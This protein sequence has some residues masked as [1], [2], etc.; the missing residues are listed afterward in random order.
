MEELY[1][2]YETDRLTLQ[3]LE[4]LRSA[5]LTEVN[6]ELEDFMRNEWMGGNLN[7]LEVPDDTQNRVRSN[8]MRQISSKHFLIPLYVKVIGW[9]AGILLPLF[10]ISTFYLY[11]ENKQ[12]VSEEMIVS[13]GIGERATI[14]LPDNTKVTLN[15]ESRLVY[16]PKIY[17]KEERRI[18]FS[19]EG[20]FNVAK[21]AERPFLIDAKGLN[22]KVLGTKFNLLVRNDEP[23][24]ELSLESGSVRFSSIVSGKYAILKPSQKVIMDQ[25]TGKLIVVG[26]EIR[27]I[28]SW[29]RNELVFRNVPLSSVVKSLEKVYGIQIDLNY[30]ECNTDLFTGTLVTND[31]NGDLEVIEKA[32]HLTATMSERKIIVSRIE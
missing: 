6:K 13:T 28:S 7:P 31:I 27:N 29:R 12:A 1:R 16:I 21:D 9:A 2:K 8:V 19:G 15:T 30:K 32:Y 23:T 17:N 4:A 3:D 24:A 18:K 22:V 11:H 10:V 25:Q 5:N 20:Y 26:D 14:T